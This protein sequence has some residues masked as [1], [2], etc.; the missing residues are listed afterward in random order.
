M[1]SSDYVWV[2]LGGASGLPVYGTDKKY[3]MHNWLITRRG[4]TMLRLFRLGGSR[5]N[6]EVCI[7]CFLDKPQEPVHKRGHA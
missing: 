6:I 2:V 1:A 4:N 5:G 3:L 7:P